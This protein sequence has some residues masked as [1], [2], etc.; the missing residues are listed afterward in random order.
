LAEGLADM[1]RPKLTKIKISPSGLGLHWPLLETDL[2]VR[3][4]LV[5]ATVAKFRKFYSGEANT[6]SLL[7]VQLRRIQ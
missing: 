2:Y 3:F 1:S 4:T 7:S 6:G 5:H